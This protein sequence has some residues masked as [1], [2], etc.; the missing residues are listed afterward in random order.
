MPG[1]THGNRGIRS[2]VVSPGI[3]SLEPDLHSVGRQP[4]G[5]L[6]FLLGSVPDAQIFYRKGGGDQN[7]G[8]VEGDVV[9]GR[10]QSG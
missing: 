7:P 3:R 1:I 4:P 10:T 9:P 2:T 8:R 5:R 6:G